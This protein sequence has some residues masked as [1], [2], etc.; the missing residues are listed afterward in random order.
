MSRMSTR[1]PSPF[2]RGG[3]GGGALRAVD[4]CELAKAAT[5]PPLTPPRE[6]GEGNT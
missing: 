1:L 3:V 2:L 5:A 6:S 4:T